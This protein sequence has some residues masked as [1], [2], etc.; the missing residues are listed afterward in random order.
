MI[1]GI[2]ATVRPPASIP[3]GRC[4]SA[5]DLSGG[6]HHR[7]RRGA[8]PRFLPELDELIIEGLVIIDPVES[9]AA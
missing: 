1:R 3:T 2:E 8:H 6:D 7:R 9:P 5:D 4:R